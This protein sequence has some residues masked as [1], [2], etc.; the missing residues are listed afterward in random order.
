[1]TRRG[2]APAL[3]R[4]LLASLMSVAVGRA[5]PAQGVTSGA[6]SGMVSDEAGR[7]LRAVQV[8]VVNRATGFAMFTRTRRDGRYLVE[9]L[10]I[11]GPYS[12]IAKG[13]GF[14]EQIRDG[15]SVTLSQSLVI[16]FMMHERAAPFGTT[17]VTG[18]GDRVLSAERTGPA[19]VVSDS[20]LHRLPTLNRNFTDFVVLAPQLS[21]A[22]PGLSAGGVN[23]RFN[24]IQIDGASEND[25]Y[26]L[27]STGQPGGQAGGKS[28]GLEAVKEYQVLLA[29]Y[30]VRQGG[31]AGALVNAVTQYGT[32]D[33]TGSA[34]YVTRRSGLA[35]NVDF[36]RMP[37]F[38]QSQMGFSLGGPIV[39]DRVHFFVSPE[40]QSEN[41]P[42]RGPYLGA[43]GGIFPVN[44]D[45]VTRFVRTLRGFG[46]EAGGA[47][48]LTLD[49]PL[50]NVFARIDVALPRNNRLVVRHNYGHAEL[51]VFSS[52]P[53]LIRLTSNG[54]DFASLKNSTVAQLYSSFGDGASNELIVGFGTIRDRR[55]AALDA[56]QVTVTVPSTSGAGTVDLRA[57]TDNFS[58][59]NLVDQNVL[60]LVDN[61]T[62][63]RG[64][65][66]ITLGAKGAW[67]HIKNLF[68]QNA[69]G[70]WEFASLD[71]LEQGIASRYQVA[72]GLGGNPAAKFDAG[73]FALYGEDHWQ[74]TRRV[75]LT[76]GARFDVPV[77]F[78][79]PQRN[80]S[81][82]TVYGR[83]TD[84][85]PS[86]HVQFSPRVGFNWNIDGDRDEQVRGGVGLFEGRPAFVWLG[87]AFQ[88]S[89]RGLGQLSCVGT[90]GA[91]V[92]PPFTSATVKTP[93]TSCADGS[94]AGGAGDIDLLSESLRFPQMMRASLAYDRRFAP[95]WSFSTEALY[96]RAI[97]TFFYT[98]LAL[99]GPQGI[100]RNGRTVYGSIDNNGVA[101]PALVGSRRNVI[102]ARDA[103]GDY[104]YGF[105]TAIDHRFTSHFELN[106]AYAFSQARDIQSLSG[107]IGATNW[108]TGR[109]IS[110]DQTDLSLGRSRFELPHHV[111]LSATYAF[112]TATD[113][114]FVYLG[115]SGASY[116]YV[117]AGSG[118]RGDLNADGATGN[119]LVYVPRTVTD[120]T[121]LVFSGTKPG[122]DNSPAAQA[123]RITDQ[124]IGLDRFIATT[125]C[126]QRNRG[127]IM[128][129]NS[130]R[131]PWTHVMNV[132]LRQSV[133][134]VRGHTLSLQMDAFNF[135]NLL[136]TE[137]GH[138]QLLPGGAGSVPLFTHVGELASPTATPF[139]GRPVLTFDP[140]ATK[141]DSRNPESVYQIQLSARYSF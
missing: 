138:Q 96:T 52:D 32:N 137:W 26:G 109:A 105:T 11:G 66:R 45:S 42:S 1:V 64:A 128:T 88:N 72:V 3:R 133:P 67:Y 99:A 130:C 125:P 89:G 25:V 100:D 68:A 119:D 21:N 60:E 49:N 13:P 20:L 58:Q 63:P 37:G 61:V 18:G 31:F 51:D 5:L 122:A 127:R 62:I 135:L 111:V 108:R 103:S 86:G 78:A 82:E 16:D 104:S 54:Y 27:G 59:G 9:G 79:T 17:P 124:Q 129:R 141:F 50:S 118:G 14:A 73:E 87:N 55:R 40:F 23:N 10:E 74:L 53:T 44:A 84:R 134:V 95:D 65:H 107:S 139:G 132:A 98:N 114:S 123:Q 33:M 75:G 121:E 101:H 91:R 83:R 41:Q 81:V 38:E 97:H 117:Y 80:A 70:A 19:T 34:F 85:V 35:R 131:T 4:L 57:G 43:P 77:L 90:P 36:V 39:R 115:Q 7:P 112:S 8:T 120:P 113:L 48:Q 6:V 29:P 2:R 46:I 71:S 94:T 15:Q 22:G 76:A 69:F 12:I 106:A 56:P 136:N 110:G 47:S 116:D 30:D 92:A 28:I 102:E 93:P 126:L 140:A 24:S